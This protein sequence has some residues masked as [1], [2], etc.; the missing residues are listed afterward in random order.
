MNKVDEKALVP[1]SSN[2]TE[3]DV[4][5]IIYT[6]GTTGKP[7][8]VELT[9]RNISTN[10]LGLKSLLKAEMGRKVSLAFL[11]WAHVFGQV[12]ELH[13]F[14]SSGSSLAIVP[15]RDQLLECIQIVK[16]T[17]L[18][19]VPIMLNKVIPDPPPPNNY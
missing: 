12:N 7:K 11:P 15:H 9:H 14:I 5:T 4:A 13:T 18:F 2:I 6:S 1:T 19:S 10:I 17:A 16:P 8:G 3:D